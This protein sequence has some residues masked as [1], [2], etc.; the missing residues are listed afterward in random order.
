MILSSSIQPDIE[1]LGIRLQEPVT[2]LT[3][4]L[5]TVVCFYAYW[6]LGKVGKLGR[7][8]YFIRIYFLL[9]G[10]AT[11]FGGLIGHGFQYVFGFNWR[12]LGWITSMLAVMFIERSAI[13]YTVNLIPRRIHRFLLWLNIIEMVAIMFLTIYYLN[14]HFVEFHAIWGFMIVVFS[15]YLFTFIKTKD[16]GS[17][18]ILYGIVILAC[19]MFVFNFQ[20]SPH[21][22][23]NHVDL[24]HVLMAIASILF[25]KGALKFGEPPELSER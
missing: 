18:W 25:L 2:T 4:L 17:R 13:E 23:F 21:L 24:S 1:F 6:K 20:V 7:T 3:D 10:F 11:F 9:M 14:F 8:I 12:L 15:F 16:V 5:V 19:A 22:W